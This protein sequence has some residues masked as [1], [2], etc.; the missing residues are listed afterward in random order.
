MPND[1][2]PNSFGHKL[3]ADTLY[4]FL[5]NPDLYVN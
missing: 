3:M 1:P 2:H 5:K 4:S